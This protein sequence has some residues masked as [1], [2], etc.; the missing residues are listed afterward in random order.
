MTQTMKMTLVGTG[1]VVILWLPA[2]GDNPSMSIAMSDVEFVRGIKALTEQAKHHPSSMLR[3]LRVIE[4][5]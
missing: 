3:Q 4:E 1:D 5:K 2:Q